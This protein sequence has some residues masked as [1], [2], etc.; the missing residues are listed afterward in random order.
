MGFLYYETWFKAYLSRNRADKAFI[1]AMPSQAQVIPYRFEA[2]AQWIGMCDQDEGVDKMIRE[3]YLFVVL[4]CSTEG[5][6]IR[7]LLSRKEHSAV[8]QA[9]AI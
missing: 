7:S 1:S 5:N 6:G 8:K 3:G 4:Y 9:N 2:G